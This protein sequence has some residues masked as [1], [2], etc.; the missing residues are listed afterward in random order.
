MSLQTE[1]EKQCSVSDRF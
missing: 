1:T